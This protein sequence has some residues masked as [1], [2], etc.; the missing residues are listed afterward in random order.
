M[1]D[2]LRILLYRLIL[3]FLKVT[4]ITVLRDSR[5]TLEKLFIIVLYTFVLM[6]THPFSSPVSLF[7]V[8]SVFSGVPPAKGSSVRRIGSVDGAKG[9]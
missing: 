4:L 2:R 3:L 5:T 6:R 8:S 1:I 7:S 9:S